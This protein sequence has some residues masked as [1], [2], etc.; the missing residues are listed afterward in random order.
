M[1]RQI[2][3][4]LGC[5]VSFIWLLAGGMS[6]LIAA[7]DIQQ[8]VRGLKAKDAAT[9]LAAVRALG[10][11]GPAAEAALP[12]LLVRL[13]DQDEAVRDA[14]AT[15]VAR[16]G[17]PAVAPVVE[18]LKKGD[19]N[20][21]GVVDERAPAFVALRTLERL[22]AQLKAE[23]AVPVLVA[24]MEASTS[25]DVPWNNA[26]EV[27]GRMGPAAVPA[28]V[29][30]LD[31]GVGVCELATKLGEAARPAVGKLLAAFPTMGYMQ[32]WEACHALALVNPDLTHTAAVLKLMQDDEY[33]MVQDIAVILDRMGPDT[34]PAIAALLGDKSQDWYPRWGATVALE[35]MGPKAKTA[36]P[37]LQQALNDE[38]EDIDVR[39]GAARAIASIQGTDPASFF[40]QIPDVQQRIV[41]STREKSLARRNQ[42]MQAEA[43]RNDLGPEEQTHGRW[44]RTAQYVYRLASNQE[45]EQANAD[46]K[47]AADA[48]WNGS[49]M[50][51]NLVRAF[52]LFHSRSE[53]FPGRLT[54]ETEAAMKKYFFGRCDNQDQSFKQWKEQGY[55]V[56]DLVPGKAFAMALH[57]NKPMN[58]TSRDYLALGVLKDDP[59]YKDKKF[60]AGDTVTERYHAWNAYFSEFL[61]DWALNGLW[62]ELG[63]TSYEYHTYPSFINLA[64]LAPDPEVRKRARMYLDL[65][66]VEAQ[67]ISIADLRAGSKS[68][69]KKGGLGSNFNPYLHMIYGERGRPLY[70]APIAASTYQAPEAAILLH[71]LGSPAPAFEIANRQ[72]GEIENLVRKHTERNLLIDSHMVNYGYRTP[73]YLMGCSMYDPNR[74]YGHGCEGRWSGIVFR[75]RAIV[76]LPAYTGEK[77]NVQSRDVMIT[78]KRHGA[79]YTGAVRIDLTSGFEK[80]ERDGWVLL[81]NGQAYAAIK[82]VTGGYTWNDPIRGSI[83]LN[84]NYSPIIIQTG[85]SADY[86]S[87]AAF[88]EAILK[89][90]LNLV[91]AAGADRKL[92]KVEYT[93]PNSSRI[94]FLLDTD[95]FILP[96]IDGKPIDLELADNYR[97]PYLQSRKG[98]ELITVRYGERSWAYDFGKNT[99]IAG[100]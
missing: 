95:P 51:V 41:Q 74:I 73:E 96:T 25:A 1:R 38:N 60:T 85:R 33:G 20:I 97:S 80:V 68:R 16:I 83:G 72:A 39:V 32:R 27:L 79:Y 58:F 59:E 61:H 71:K 69:A 31:R 81:D 29:K 35:M 67:Q 45:V 99:V 63:S 53:H 7:G 50:D 22:D 57:A 65:C 40:A 98:S 86:G 56:K 54:P 6:P 21:V 36:L 76:S 19:L 84:D 44:E 94:E 78:Q 55:S 14:A 3:T 70:H 93:G 9:R 34:V 47:R 26:L 5:F 100:R 91:F 90:P 75:N 87:F 64:D 17:K 48:G 30:Q 62:V 46:L 24:M 28:M 66:L 2:S 43:R 4:V 8:E 49:F 92:K 11:R 77:W 12:D 13:R 37:A 10:E 89:A 42:F 52:L 88:Q 23:V 82:I 15:T 18:M